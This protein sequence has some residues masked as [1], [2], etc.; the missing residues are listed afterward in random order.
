MRNKR[1]KSD[2]KYITK[3]CEYCNAKFYAKRKTAKFCCDACRVYNHQEQ[4]RSDNLFGY[5]PNKGKLL[6]PGTIPSQEMSEDKLVFFGNLASLY[7][8]LKNYIKSPEILINEKEFIE[9]LDSYSITND[10]RVSMTQIFTD[11]F[12]IEVFRIFPAEYKLYVEP[13][14][15]DNPKPFK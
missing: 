4:H 9:Q 14:G 1:K 10:W 13:W 8:E 11:E 12:S 3:I 15:D 6:A 7:R 5:D 2:G